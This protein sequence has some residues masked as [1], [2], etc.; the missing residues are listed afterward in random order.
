MFTSSLIRLKLLDLL[1][2][3]FIYFQ[4]CLLSGYWIIYL[5]TDVFI[6]LFIY[7]IFKINYNFWYMK[8]KFNLF[9]DLLYSVIILS[10]VAVITNILAFLL[11]M[12]EGNTGNPN[13]KNF[14]YDLDETFNLNHYVGDQPQSL[15]EDTKLLRNI[16]GEAEIWSS[17]NSS[18][19]PL[20][21]EIEYVNASVISQQK[22]VINDD[23]QVLQVTSKY[24]LLFLY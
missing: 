24:L 7:F 15:S 2:L 16:V 5:Y 18:K 12:E 14:Q 20:K 21:M 11:D 22:T 13:C 23:D 6:Y 8:I 19:I 3:Y 4:T 17:D 1:Y 10:I 9:M